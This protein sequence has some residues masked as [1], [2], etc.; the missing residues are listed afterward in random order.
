MDAQTV[1]NAAIGMLGFAPIVIFA[2]WNASRHSDAAW[3][4]IGENKTLWITFMIGGYFIAG[5][6]LAV[7]FYYLVRLR[8]ELERAEKKPIQTD[9]VPH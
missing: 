5:L 2:T 9:P 7:A 1:I 3:E 8:G 6:G 4:A